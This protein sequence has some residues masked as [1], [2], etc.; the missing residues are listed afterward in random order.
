M[1]V[2]L[3][4]AHPAE[5][6]AS[7]LRY[8]I[9]LQEE[10][11]RSR[12]VVYDAPYA[13]PAFPGSGAGRIQRAISRY[14]VA[15]LA[16]RALPSPIVHILDHSSAHL[17]PYIL[18]GK[19]VLVTLHDLIPLR[20]AGFLS[21]TQQDRY[22]RCVRN[23]ALADH[24][25]CVSE[26]TRNEA[27]E[28]LGIPFEKMTVIPE[29]SSLLSA[30]SADPSERPSDNTIRILSVGSDLPRKNLRILP[31]VAEGLVQAGYRVELLRVGALLGESLK[32]EF[33]QLDA[34]RFQ[35]RELGKSDDSVLADCYRSVDCVLIPS[36]LEGF[37]LPVLEAMALGCPV[38]CSNTTALPEAGGG[39]ALYFDPLDPGSAVIQILRLK[40]N[41]TI[42]RELALLGR[43]RSDLLSWTNH[44]EGVRNIYQLLQSGG[45]GA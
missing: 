19:K 38:V 43:E 8:W 13:P 42:S 7:M 21:K 23:L 35:L 34:T 16:A 17:I 24:I 28:L 3:L 2:S 11:S 41:P 15:P 26:Y 20:D 30:A 44:F 4:P 40:N 39:A 10:A 6:S 12:D 18:V 32:R 29:G 37:G 36:L 45:R 5:G 22:R 27:H 31:L 14:L 33:E 25:I 1:H 9:M